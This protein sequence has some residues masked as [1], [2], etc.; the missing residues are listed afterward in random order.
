MLVQTKKLV[1]HV[2]C[3]IVISAM[4]AQPRYVIYVS[5]H[6]MDMEQEHVHLVLFQ[7][8]MSVILNLH[9][10]INAQKVI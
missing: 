3:Q 6:F 9:T 5:L 7:I 1:A 2:L 8:V 4:L 10:V